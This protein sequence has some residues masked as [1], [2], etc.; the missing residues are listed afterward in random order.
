MAI[1]EIVTGGYGNTT[2]NGTIPLVVMRG[3]IASTVVTVTP[4]R[5]IILDAGSSRTLTVSITDR[6]ID[7]TANN[8]TR[9]IK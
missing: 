9:L 6:D 5:R 4:G 2:F 8:R 7:I 1:R 3:F